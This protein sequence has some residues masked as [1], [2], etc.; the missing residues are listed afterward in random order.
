MQ[1]G[2]SA[3]IALSVKAW[4]DENDITVLP[5]CARLPD[6]NPIENLWSWMDRRLAKTRMHTV[7]ELKEEVAKHWLEIPRELCMS[8]IES[9]SKRVRAGMLSLKKW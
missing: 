2:A 5:W 3:H 8:L 6:L 7:D 9:M 1:D 4:F